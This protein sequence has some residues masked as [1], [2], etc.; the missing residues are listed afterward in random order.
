MPVDRATFIRSTRRPSYSTRSATCSYC[1]TR[2]SIT[3]AV[4]AIEQ[5]SPI[6]A[7]QSVI[8]ELTF[9]LYRINLIAEVRLSPVEQDGL[10]YLRETVDS[11]LSQS[12]YCTVSLK[13]LF[14]PF[15]SVPDLDESI[16]EVGDEEGV[17][18]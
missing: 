2:S 16:M 5:T 15:H 3:R 14:Q 18:E 11:C 6:L 17:S 13:K 9:P 4:S 7:I 8:I 1:S 10:N 12:H